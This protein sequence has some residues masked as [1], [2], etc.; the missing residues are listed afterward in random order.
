[1]NAAALRTIGHQRCGSPEAARRFA[2]QQI[3]QQNRESGLIHL[4]AVPIGTPI[5]PHVLRP[6][7]VGFLR[8]FE[9]MQHAESIVVGARCQQSTGTLDQIAWPDQVIAA[10][11]FIAFVEAPGNGKAGDDAAEKILGFVGAQTPP[12]WRDTDLFAAAS[13]RASSSDFCQCCQC[14]T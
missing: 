5:E 13:R 6:M 3:D 4:Q 12:R 1:M 9:I 7:S 2:A 10:Q 14:K 8:G 11:V